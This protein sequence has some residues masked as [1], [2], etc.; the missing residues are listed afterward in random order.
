MSEP[1]LVATRSG[2]KLREIR[3]ILAELQV[4]SLIDPDGAGIAVDPAEDGIEVFDTFAGNALAKARYFA[5]RSGL[6]TLADDSGLCVDALD[7]GPG[8]RSRRFSGRADLEGEALDLANN[9]LLLEK[10][11]GVP[12][13]GR[14][15]HYLCVAAVVDPATGE[16]SWF[17]GRCD[18]VILDAPS[19][20]S[21]FG[22]DPLFLVPSEGRSFGEIALA[23]KNRISHRAHAMRAAASALHRES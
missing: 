17:E 10:L 15:A 1:V 3:E 19:G 18:G 5:A 23:R 20:A 22:Y 16:E 21:G 11:R 4:G 9:A 7:G 13:D 6:L 8:V 12:S 2:H 14:T